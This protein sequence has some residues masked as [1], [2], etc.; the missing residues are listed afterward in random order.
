MPIQKFTGPEDSGASGFV[1]VDVAGAESADG[2]VRCAKKILLDGAW[3]M[4]RSRTYA[5]AL[6]RVARSGASAALNVEPAHRHRGIDAFIDEVKPRVVA[7][8]LSLDAGKGISA[9]DLAPLF[10]VDVRSGP[11]GDR[12][13]HATVADALN[14]KSATV[15]A[16]TALDG[17]TGA[18]VAIEGAGPAAS[19]LGADLIDLVSEAGAILIAVG[20]STGTLVDQSGLD[21]AATAASWREHGD[22]LP[23][24]HGSESPPHDVMSTPS[25]VIFCGSKLG[26]IDHLV[27][28]TLGAKVVAPIGVAPVTAK[29]LAVAGRSGTI[30]LADFLTTSG[31]L[32]SFNPGA[33]ADIA[34]LMALVER[35]TTD[36]TATALSHADGAYMGSCVMA[37]EFL[38]GWVDEL[39]FGRPLA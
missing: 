25:D 30:V 17:L 11:H 35:T 7:G 19:A 27:A 3:T 31:A 12:Y 15:A 39:P 29:G 5:W 6:L 10:E 9:V 28:E 26:L 37:E 13:G 8:E 14:A 22:S 38:S 1:I 33:S 18:K 20:T 4:A 16:A 36:L 32:H 24:A 34:E 21:P 2:Q 23:A